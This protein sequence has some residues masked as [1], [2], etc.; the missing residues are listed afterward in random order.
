MQRELYNA[1]VADPA[2]PHFEVQESYSLA[3]GTLDIVRWEGDRMLR[4]WKPA[5][6]REHLLMSPSILPS[7]L[8]S[9]LP[10][11]G[12]LGWDVV[13]YQAAAKPSGRGN[14]AT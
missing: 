1:A 12:C 11:R 7:I 3:E 14:Q 6:K 2:K 5:G 10:A 4:V 9:M 8:P 13:R